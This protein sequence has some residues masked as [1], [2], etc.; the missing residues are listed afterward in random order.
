MKLALVSDIHGNLTALEA[1]LQDLERQGVDQV[2][3][4]GDTALTGPQPQETL[5]RLQS[6]G[7]PTVMGNA[8]ALILEPHF[9]PNDPQINELDAWCVDQVQASQLEF[10]RSFQATLTLE[11][12]ETRLLCFHGSPRG[13]N[14]IILAETPKDALEPMLTA[15]APIM[16]GG[17]THQTML[18][19]Y[20]DELIINPGSVGL[21]YS[22]IQGDGALAAFAE[23]AI[24]HFGPALNAV[25]FRR[26]P[27]DPT[28]V[29]RAFR[30]NYPP[31][32]EYWAREW[33][34]ARA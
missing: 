24:L 5:T 18:R 8:D 29:S 32:A 21:A 4:L 2:V 25:E 19:R 15:R 12:P 11:L 9:K 1:V 27:F 23:Y 34:N 17:H 20:G 14:D 28:H 10:V 7:W 31:H 6:L 16:A 26:V 22:S 30:E 3:N 33:Q 13:F